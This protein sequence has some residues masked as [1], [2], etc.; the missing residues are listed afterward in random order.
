MAGKITHKKGVHASRVGSFVEGFTL[1][2]P[3][4]MT[5][6]SYVGKSISD[7]GASQIEEFIELIRSFDDGNERVK[8]QDVLETLASIGNT[9]AGAIKAFENCDSLT[10]AN[11]INGLRKI[12]L[13]DFSAPTSDQ[14]R[15]ASLLALSLIHISE[16]TRPY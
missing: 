11:I 14:V 9:K 12:G 13:K 10:E 4:R 16:P 7:S 3:H 1:A 6:A 5:L 2:L 15:A 8:N